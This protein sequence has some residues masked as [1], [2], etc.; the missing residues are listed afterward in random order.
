M[1]KSDAPRGLRNDRRSG[2]VPSG[3]WAQ[4]DPFELPR[5]RD[6]LRLLRFID[7]LAGHL[8]DTRDADS[9]LRFVVRACRE[10]FD[11]AA[12]SL[13]VLVPPGTRAQVV[14][15]V[16]QTHVW[17]LPLFAAVLQGAKPPVQPNLMFARLRRRERPWG[18]LALRRA[19]GEFDRNERQALVRVGASV[20][21]LLR[22][23]DLERIREV[24]DRI[25][26]KIMSELRPIDLSY[27][28]LDALRSLTGYDHSSAVLMNH[29][30]SPT[31]QV[32]AEQ[33][34]WRK[35][36]SQRVGTVLPLT[37]SLAKLLS[38]G[39]VFGF[40]R[41]DDRWRE[42]SGRDDAVELAELLDY[43]RGDDG[44]GHGR[45]HAE[46]QMLCAALGGRDEVLGVLKVAA[47][48]PNTFG[49]YESDLLGAFLPQATIAVQNAQRTESLQSKMI[50][51]ERKHAMADLAR[52]VSHDLNN[53]MGSVLPLVEQMREEAQS[54]TID[55]RT[56]V[57]DLRQ[58]E[59]SLLVCRRIFNGMLTFAR[60]SAGAIG[61][62]QVRPAVECTLAIL[63]ENLRRRGIRVVLDL[64]EPLP[65]TTATQSD[66]EQLMLNLL[67]NARDAMP[68]G[69]ELRIV[70]AHVRDRLNIAVED[71]G[72]GIPSGDLPRV[73]DPFFTT[74]Q[75]G[76]G[77]GLS[78]CR[79]IVW[80]M[81]GELRF[82]STIGKGT[83][84]LLNLPAAAD[85]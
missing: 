11:V 34:A 21:R 22:E 75:N 42:W 69:G 60:R 65:S 41:I 5:L 12:A 51:A 83:K 84:V 9:A 1:A 68:D 10:H 80:D 8:R 56:S 57:E 3:A 63:E 53:A 78:I 64:C 67:T 27:Q 81:G 55:L 85:A 47:V 48:H 15:N 33:I 59:Q 18:V 13:S 23:I 24:R 62:G 36:R 74:K 76:S 4:K 54:G 44:V 20:S 82:E 77:L 79:S 38:G 32:V 71:T 25:D 35:A 66:L 61:Q 6:E 17:D 16:P 14:F 2:D 70:A 28:I 73:L 50:A 39:E 58:I 19:S 43:N 29:G 46:A 31:L 30:D 49:T 72:V 40:T 52:G 45:E 26:R 37:P 7:L